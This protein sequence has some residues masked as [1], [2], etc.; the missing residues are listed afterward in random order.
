MNPFGVA[1]DRAFDHLI[2]R[3]FF[4]GLAFDTPVGDPGWF[5]RDSAVWYVHEHVPALVTGLFASALIETLHPDFAWMGRDHSRSVERI[6][7]VATGRMD[8]EGILQRAGHSY[9][10]FMTVAY[11][12]TESAE[13]VTRAVRGM[14]SA[15]RGTRPD[16]RHYDATDPDT[17]R[18][19]YATVVWGLATAH[20]RYHAR[21]LRDIDEYYGQ[22]VRVGE[23]LGGTD[24]P[25]TKASVDAYLREHVALMG[26]T[27]PTVS[28]LSSLAG[29]EQPRVIRP[30]LRQLEW[31]VLDLQPDWAQT[32]LRFSPGPTARMRRA[33]TWCAINGIRYGAGPLPEVTDARARALAPKASAWRGRAA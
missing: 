32:L 1:Q 4:R 30:V 17:L 20:E 6:N 29:R 8:E 7:G 33:A 12:S 22:F 23:E 25:A 19:A 5:G 14:H 18:W 11:G 9:S 26:V 10:F 15:V 28:F 16:G 31:A 27:M 2:R 13:R 3:R 24:L 21:P